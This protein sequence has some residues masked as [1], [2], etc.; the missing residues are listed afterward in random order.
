MQLEIKTA[1]TNVKVPPERLTAMK[2]TW[3]KIWYYRAYYAIFLPVFVFAVLFKYLPMLGVRYAFYDFT[4]FKQKF[5]GLENFEDL[6]FGLKATMFWRSFGNTIFLSVVNLLLATVIS[7]AVALLLNEIASKKLRG[8]IQ[9]V[10]YLPH[11]MSW[12]VVAS[13]FVI[14][15]SPSGGFINSIRGL[16]GADPIYFLAEEKWWTPIYLFICRWKD[17]GWGTIIYLAALSGIDPQL[18]EAAS[19]DG[20]GKWK[21]T[22]KITLPSISTTIM[23][24]FVLNLGKIMNIFESV[25]VLQNDKVQNVADVVTTF[26]YRIGIQ[27][28]DYGMGTAIGLFKSVVGLVLVLITDR[29]NKKIRGSSLL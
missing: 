9:T 20:A 27:G 4:P 10:L 13:V 18:Y 19:M 11:F 3:K 8:G 24:V 2:K 23:T 25:F 26:A 7:V 1:A 5:V 29:I 14:I 12:V 28:A 16:F 6:F 22:L 15:L 17:T 21:Q